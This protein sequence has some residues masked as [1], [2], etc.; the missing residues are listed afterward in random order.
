LLL[1]PLG[2]QH[3]LL[4]LRHVLLELL[5]SLLRFWQHPWLHLHQRHVL[6]SIA[7]GLQVEMA[8]NHVGQQIISNACSH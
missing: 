8:V 4:S 7:Q 1:V 2:C 6:H 5:C 3:S